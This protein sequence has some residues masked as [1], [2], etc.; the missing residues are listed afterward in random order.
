MFYRTKIADDK[1]GEKRARIQ[2][3]TR[4]IK[5]RSKQ[6]DRNPREESR[7]GFLDR[8]PREKSG[9]GLQEGFKR[10]IRE[11]HPGEDS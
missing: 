2:F 1:K 3:H 5:I 7:R 9:R 6:T 4:A 11:R 10:E 8:N